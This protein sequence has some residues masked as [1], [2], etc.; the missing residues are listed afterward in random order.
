M[1]LSL[2]YKKENNGTQKSNEALITNNL[3][4]SLPNCHVRFV[5]KKGKYKVSG[6][7]I[8][9]VIET[10]QFSVLDINIDIDASSNN[11][12]KVSKL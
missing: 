8:Y 4:V 1:N 9:Q 10:S 3:D 5:M 2:V 12:I 11:L 6:G 7:T